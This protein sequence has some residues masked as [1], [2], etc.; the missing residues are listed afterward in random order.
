MEARA[1]VEHLAILR[2]DL[3]GAVLELEDLRV[4]AV[5]GCKWIPGEKMEKLVEMCE[6]RGGLVKG[7]SMNDALG[8][9]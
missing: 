6:G 4:L 5:E 9:Y 2:E 3:L 7:L 8:L 1:D